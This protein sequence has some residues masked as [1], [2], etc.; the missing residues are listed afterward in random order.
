MAGLAN[1]YVYGGRRG[2]ALIRAA[3]IGMLLGAGGGYAGRADDLFLGAVLAFT[4]ESSG[5]TIESTLS[6]SNEETR[7]PIN[8]W[9]RAVTGRAL[10]APWC[11]NSRGLAQAFSRVTKRSPHLELLLEPNDRCPWYLED[12]ETGQSIPD[13]DFNSFGYS[14]NSFVGLR[15]LEEYI[16]SVK[17]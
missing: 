9:R 12:F 7:Q 6:F 3:I 10:C 15:R 13:F 11:G 14:R 17:A 2:T 4:A 16:P 8:H 1:Q 5:T